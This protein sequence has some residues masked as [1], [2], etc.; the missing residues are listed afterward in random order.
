[1]AARPM[2]S[3]GQMSRQAIAINLA[4]LPSEPESDGEPTAYPGAGPWWPPHGPLAPVPVNEPTGERVHREATDMFNRLVSQEVSCAVADTLARR[5]I[6]MNLAVT[7][8]EPA[9]VTQ[10]SMAIYVRPLAPREG[11]HPWTVYVSQDLADEG[12]AA[13]EPSAAAI[14][15]FAQ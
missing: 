8:V 3:H 13:E 11:E 4:E 6:F 2:A 1:M 5:G 7:C 12:S 9:A 10:G 14:G 15:P